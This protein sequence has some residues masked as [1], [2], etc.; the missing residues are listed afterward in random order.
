MIVS[1]RNFVLLLSSLALGL[2]SCATAT[3][4][5]GD[6][7][8]L[9][10]Q[11]TP[12]QELLAE[13]LSYQ[14]LF[15]DSGPA[16]AKNVG[17][18]RTMKIHV[19]DL[20]MAHT[21][22]QQLVNGVPV[23][24]GEA[25]VHLHPNGKLFTIT[26]DLVPDVNVDTTP[27]YTADEAI[28][29]AAD[30]YFDGM[31]KLSQDPIA[32]LWVLRR[33]GK[34]H[35]VWRVQLASLEGNDPTMPVMFV[36][37]HSGDLVWS[38]DNL[39]TAVS[40]TCSGSTP[41]YSTV[42]IKCYLYSGTYYLEN[43]D[44]LLGTYTWNNTTS[45]LYYV[46]STS[47][48]FGTTTATKN[49]VEAHYTV[50]Q[51]YNYYYST[52]GR[53]GINGSGGPGAMTSH[54]YSFITSTASYSRSYVNAYWDSTNLYMVYG[55]GDGT[56]SGSLTTLDVGG[57]ELT[58]GVTQYEANLTYSGESG[59]LN[60]SMSDVF[61]AM[62]ERYAEGESTNTWLIGEATWTPSTSGDALRYMNDP[63]A[64]GY[65]LDYY[66]SSAAST[67]VH[68]SSGISNLAFYLLSKGGTHPRGKSSTVV[69]AIGADEASKI[70][71]S[72]LAD[73]M[74]SST[75]FSGARTATLSAASALYGAS[76]TEYTQVG[77]AWSAVGVGSSSGG[78]SSSSCTT[79]SYSGSL[80]ARGKSAYEPSS[81]GT[82]VSVSSQ[83][84]S[85][86]GPSSADFDLYLQKKSGSSW[87][88][89]AS[90]TGSTSS[91]SISYSGSSGTYRVM[92]YSYSGSGSFAVSWCK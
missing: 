33:D 75:T 20:H 71:Y 61:G 58:H 28:E 17:E 59:G 88:S 62:V 69:T 92:V 67:D 49:A 27:E 12:D 66:T 51:V 72:A 46:S 80:S 85:L 56:T 16:M 32:D 22:V 83:T 8:D 13:D 47:T 1:H 30:E 87:S 14:Q 64:D 55:D 44:N 63:A 34:D 86:T 42:S 82:S 40:S 2:A 60:E 31:D 48:T 25:I 37:A 7:A 36:D 76:S 74:T 70:W 41:H 81:S 57:H 38:Y 77:N 43:P 65:S 3:P 5:S 21:R 45:S 84:V 90:S 29:L 15:D 23:F 11:D 91:E 18:L 39:Q 4:V 52:F 19:D 89:V 79:A 10:A 78:G 35:L 6:D 53:N 73:Y 50:Q 26:D 54:G 24:G 68:Y 9:F